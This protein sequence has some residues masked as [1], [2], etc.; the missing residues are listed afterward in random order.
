MGGIGKAST[1]VLMMDSSW[2]R[3]RPMAQSSNFQRRQYAERTAIN[4]PMQ[5]TAADLIKMAMI[6]VDQWI[7]TQQPQ[8]RMILQVH[9]ELVLEAPKELIS[10]V[11][12]IASA[13]MIDVAQ[14]RVPLEVE[15]GV[16]ENWAQA[17]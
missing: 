16:G 12:E 7:L 11:T 6:K 15:A 5:G 2:L 4:A 3:I 1:L 17:H 13:I 8:V 9:D 14:L 10:E